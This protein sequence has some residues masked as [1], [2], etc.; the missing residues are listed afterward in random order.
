MRIAFVLLILASSPVAAAPVPGLF[1]TG[2]DNNHVALA[3]GAVDPHYK[4]VASA[5]PAYS[6]PNAYAC[7][8]IAGGY[9]LA[10]DAQSRWIG[11]AANEGYPSG[12]P[13]H[14]E[15]LYTFRLSFDLSG[16]DTTTVQI[17]GGWCADNNG[18][19][20]LNGHPAGAGT[21]GYGSLT[22]FTITTGFKGGINTLEFSSYNLG[23]GGANPTAI[24]VKGLAGTGTPLLLGVND[25]SPALALAAP[26][27]NPSLGS[28]RIG[29]TLARSGHVRL[30]IR[31][32][33]GRVVC[34]LADRDSGPGPF[35][36]AW[37]GADAPPGIYFV[38]LEQAGT[39]VSRRLVRMR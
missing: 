35:E 12:A 36:T 17:S 23:G 8:P 38:V 30:T 9:W 15:G 4:L 3:D 20:T 33:V 16:F 25:A 29:Y 5:D 34:E 21:P 18:S 32:V 10:N 19:M 7:W 31:N 13:S 27:P 11:P 28:A 2:V 1:D 6:G 39:S 22:P 26:I 14:P 37:D 24:R